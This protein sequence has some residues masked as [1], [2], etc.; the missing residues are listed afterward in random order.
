MRI[1]VDSDWIINCLGAVPSSLAILESLR[2]DGLAISAFTVAEVLEGAYGEGDPAAKLAEY[3]RFLY[4]FAVL[5][6]TGE[7]AEEFARLRPFLRRQGNSI[8][9]MDLLIAATA[10]VH[11]LTLLTRNLRHFERVPGLQLYRPVTN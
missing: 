3:R 9:D 11:G 2:A 4:G 7:V 8:P 1:V 5:P 6:V 10:L